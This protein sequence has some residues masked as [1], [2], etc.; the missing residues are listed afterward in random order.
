MDNPV[1]DGVIYE[2]Y[3]LSVAGIYVMKRNACDILFDGGTFTYNPDTNTLT[4]NGSY[5]GGYQH[6]IEYDGYGN[7]TIYVAKDAELSGGNPDSFF[8]LE[9][10]TTITGPGKLT[11]GG[12]IAV[13]NG[14]R[15]SI[16][17][18]NIEIK[19]TGN[20]AIRGNMGGERLVI[21]N[22]NIHAESSYRAIARFDGGI[23]INHSM[24]EDGLRIIDD[25]GYICK[26]D[27]SN[28]N[29][30][31][32]YNQDYITGLKDFKDSK[33]SKDLIFNLSGQRLSKPMKGINI[34]DGKKIVVR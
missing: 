9:K 31:N 23:T 7:L 26:T 22:S 29:I 32:I 33:D 16:K 14:S 11:L 10:S 30:V 18:A 17:D 6:M 19:Q 27:G 8:C 5:T 21:D 4:I 12:N 25:F 34:I 1:Y 20:Y 24:L 3:D 28:A 2:E 15:L 13:L